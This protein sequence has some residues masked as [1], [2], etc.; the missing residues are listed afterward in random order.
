MYVCQEVLH[1]DM[2]A[3][4]HQAADDAKATLRLL[5]YMLQH[6]FP[7]PASRGARAG[8]PMATHALVVGMRQVVGRIRW[9][10][11]EWVA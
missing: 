6:V 2:G 8:T 1:Y 10:R 11:H 7:A 9:L 3:A 5:E 4:A